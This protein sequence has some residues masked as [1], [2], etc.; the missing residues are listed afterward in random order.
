MVD[1]TWYER[2][3]DVPEDISAGGIVVR[4][5]EDRVYVALAREIEEEVGITDLTAGDGANLGAD[6]SGNSKAQEAMMAAA[7]KGARLAIVGLGET[8]QV[9]TQYTMIRV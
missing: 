4:R 5:E 6:Y 8:F 7:A 1:E 2:P 3:E 9:D